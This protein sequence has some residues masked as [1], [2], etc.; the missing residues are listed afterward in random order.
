MKLIARVTG[1]RVHQEE[2]FEGEYFF[3]G[4]DNLRNPDP[5]DSW[6]ACIAWQY[7]EGTQQRTMFRATFMRM[8]SDGRWEWNIE[9]YED[10]DADDVARGAS[11]TLDGAVD[12]VLALLD[13]DLEA[14]YRRQR[15]AG[16]AW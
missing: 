13:G 3:K 14:R 2:F 12:A 16:V 7:R 15:L 8:Y 1:R 9:A 6:F 4:C 10:E 11:P 5:S